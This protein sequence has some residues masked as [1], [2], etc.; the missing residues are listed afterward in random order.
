MLNRTERGLKLENRPIVVCGPARSGTTVLQAMLNA[1]PAVQIAREVPLDRLPAL[2]SLLKEIGDYH[3]DE[4]TEERRAEVVRALWFAASRPAPIKPDARRWGMK[5][6]WSE[7]DADLW[8]SLVSPLYVYTL[9]RGDRV[10]QSH[11]R[12]G[13]GGGSPARLI[14]RYKASIRAYERLH[15][16]GLAHMVQVDR[17]EGPRERRQSG[18]AVFSFIGEDPGEDL[19]QLIAGW[20][21]RLNQATSTP[22]ERPQ[23]PEE[24]SQRLAGDSE[25]Q[26]MM[27]AYGY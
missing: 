18:E 20:E 9:R 24:W 23:L 21:E 26:E 10:F 16:A 14:E 6:P 13:W 1:H 15:A 27:A 4:W 2:R 25:Y 11:I 8:S 22:G 19:L 7:L 3:R 12:L 5:T 17:S